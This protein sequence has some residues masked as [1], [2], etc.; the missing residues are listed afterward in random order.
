MD[1]AV[2]EKLGLEKKEIKVYLALLR[3][4]SATATKVSQESRIERTLTYT[5]LEKLIDKGLVSYVLKKNVKH[6]QAADP[7]KL[8]SDLE[9]K[10]EQLQQIMPN[11]VNLAKFVKEE[12][13]VEIYKGKEGL[14]TVFRDMIRIGKDY[15][16]LGEEAV[17]HEI[18]PETLKE[19]LREIVKKGIKERVLSK[20]SLRGKI[21]LTKNSKIKYL[22]D[23]YFS[24]V[25]TVVYGDRTAMVIW[26]DPI[27]IILIHNNS[28]AQ[29]YKNYFEFFWKMAKK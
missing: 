3:L 19:I 5:I 2:L 4:T 11:L 8:M 29:T 28:V 10:K 20:E 25:M 22:P 13:K 23:D 27:N 17:F 21:W 6:F 14:R 16:V 12:T 26:A 7:R 18:M 9:E 24:P 1:T 15:I